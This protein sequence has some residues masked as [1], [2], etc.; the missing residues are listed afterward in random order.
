VVD[1]CAVTTLEGLLAFDDKE[2]KAI[3]TFYSKSRSISKVMNY[4]NKYGVQNPKDFRLSVVNYDSV[5]ESEWVSYQSHNRGS[6]SHVKT[7]FIN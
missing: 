4:M 2:L 3:D 5:S 6:S 7:S 1:A